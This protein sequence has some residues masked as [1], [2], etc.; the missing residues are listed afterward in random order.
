MLQPPGALQYCSGCGK[1]LERTQSLF[2]KPQLG[3]TYNQVVA[4]LLAGWSMVRLCLP[5]SRAGLPKAW[6]TEAT[7]SCLELDLAGALDLPCP[8]GQLATCP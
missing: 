4:L 8:A 6:A 7:H 1:N 5:H 2:T 3:V